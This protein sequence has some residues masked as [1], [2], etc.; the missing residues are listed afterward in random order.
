MTPPRLLSDIQN[1]P[2]SLLRIAD[3]HH[4]AGQRRLLEAATLVRSRPRTVIVGMGASLHAAI[5]LENLLCSHGL[6]A[7][8]IE[9]GEL[10]HFRRA[11]YLDAVFIVV[12]RSGESI[13]I[14]NFLA[15][16]RGRAPVIALTNAPSSTLARAATV[17]L[18]LHSPADDMV[19]IQTHTGTLLTLHLLGMAILGKV[20]VAQRECGALLGVFPSWV[21]TCLDSILSWDSFLPTDVPVYTLGR[22]PSY[23]SA[24]QGALLFSEIAKTPA[25]AM[26]VAAFRHGPV[27]VVDPRFRAMI[28]A[29][30]GGTRALNIGLASDLQRFGGTVRL[31]GPEGPDAAGLPWIHTPA[32][33]E[34]L[35]PLLE[36]VP[37]QVAA[38]RLAQLRGIAVGSFRFAPQVATDE[39]RIVR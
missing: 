26:A 31:I 13:E 24:L 37:L 9:A 19:A 15:A 6:A 22:G 8:S 5:P 38:L 17:A 23:G 34:L 29:P 12:S 4:G 2:D 36:V 32:C 30:R 16:L 33:S 27:E 3:Y 7:Q 10:L 28:F 11:A 39:A 18:E 14:V 1:Q 25:V 20:E 21:V 35:A